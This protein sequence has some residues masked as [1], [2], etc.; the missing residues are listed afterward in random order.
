M[1]SMSQANMEH[2]L[3]TTTVQESITLCKEIQCTK[4]NYKSKGQLL[5]CKKFKLK[6]AQ[7]CNLK[8][9]TQIM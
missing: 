9:Q 6:T 4:Y 8:Q 7:K 2:T 1:K 3:K 5:P